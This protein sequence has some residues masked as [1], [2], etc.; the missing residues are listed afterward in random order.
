MLQAELA[1]SGGRINPR[2][3]QQLLQLASMSRGGQGGGAGGAGGGA[4]SGAGAMSEEEMIQRAM[5]ESLAGSRGSSG[6]GSSS[7]ASDSQ[8]ES[9]TGATSG[10]PD[11]D[12]IARAMAQ[13]IGSSAGG[14]EQAGTQAESRDDLI[15]RMLAGAGSGPT[16]LSAMLTAED[17]EGLLEDDSVVQRL[18]PHLPEGQQDRQSLREIVS[19]SKR[20]NLLLP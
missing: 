6:Q 13:A 14:G 19:T 2:R 15:R 12:E 7:R 9:T 1:R 17:M 20:P 16:P 8:R 18:L 10:E 5:M 4:G 11:L 3:F